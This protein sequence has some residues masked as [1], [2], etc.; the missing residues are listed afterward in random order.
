MPVRLQANA[1]DRLQVLARELPLVE[2]LPGLSRLLL[3]R[4]GHLLWHGHVL[5][6]DGT[7]LPVLDAGGMEHAATDLLPRHDPLAEAHGLRLASLPRAASPG[8]VADAGLLSMGVLALRT[9]LTLRILDMSH[10]HLAKRWSFGK[11]T[12]SHQ[13]VKACFATVFAGLQQLREQWRVRLEQGWL[14]ELEDEHRHLS[15]L[16]GQAEKLMGGHGYLQAGSHGVSYL[17]MLLY[18]LYGANRES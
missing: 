1:L 15:E 8:S 9:G 7:A 2:A 13:L 16:T 5:M 3:G 11:K 18:S 10:Q 6:A 12:L 4:D 14:G 17:S